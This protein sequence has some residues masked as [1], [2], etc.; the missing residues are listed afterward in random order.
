MQVNIETTFGVTTVKLIGDIDAKSAP[1]A[2]AQILPLAGED[3]KIILDMNEVGYMSSA[4]LRMLLAV[5]RSIPPSGRIV[6][7]GLSEALTET[8]S[9]TGFLDF[10]TVCETDEESLAALNS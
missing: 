6:L 8:M 4:G 9:V 10:F 3:C 5:R 2:Q 7:T 1:P